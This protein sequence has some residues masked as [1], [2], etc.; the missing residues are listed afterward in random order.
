MIIQKLFNDRVILA[1]SM[2]KDGNMRAFSETE[3]DEVLKNQNT[4]VTALG[5]HSD[6]TA[7]VLTT[8]L[9][10]KSFTEY[11]EI[12]N[13]TITKHVINKPETALK[14]ADGLVTRTRD[15]TLLLPLADCLGVV[16]FD[17]EQNILGLLHSGR[18]NLE[19]DGAY[20]FVES[21][22][23]NYNCKPQNLKVYLTAHAQ[24]FEIYALNHAKLAE[25]AREQLLRAGIKSENIETSDID[26]VT[27]PDFPSNSTGD[28]TTRFAV[29]VKLRKRTLQE[30]L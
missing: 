1:T 12:N 8:Y 30:H 21:L 28:K 29:A 24:N 25:A 20:K 9:E 13:Q 15:Y 22:K 4:I 7:R 6:N 17:S 5:G 23:Q 2:R 14:L 10:R 27:N 11:Y 18:Q 3:F 19:E 16:F 26:T